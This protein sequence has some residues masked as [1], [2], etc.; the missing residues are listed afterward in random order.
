[1]SSLNKITLFGAGG[2]NIGYHLIRAF[3]A[4]GAYHVTVLARSAS[5]TSYPPAVKL[6]K[7]SDFED[8]EELVQAL[9]GQYVLIS[10]VGP[11]AFAVQN[12]LVD[13]CLRAGVTRF[14][15]TEWGFDNDDTACRELCP[16]VFGAKGRF[17]DDVLRP[18]EGEL[19]WTAVASSIWLDWALDTKFLGIDPEA[20]TVR[21]WRDGSAKWSATTL[22]Y[23]AAA[24]VQILK[25]HRATANRRIFL[26]PFETSQREIVAELERQQGVK[27]DEL[28][29]DADAEV[30]AAEHKWTTE[31][32]MSSVYV[33]IPAVVLLPEY[34]TA[35]QTRAKFPIAEAIE[36]VKLPPMSVAGV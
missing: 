27:Y 25:N 15:P 17:V 23:T 33:T 19:E 18:K 31:N 13:A 10:C 36:G 14:I 30:A 3:L 34:G 11:G 20:H 35:F 29:F 12:D 6:V 8:H 16:P 7:I 24:V 26:S 1:M 22:P 4:D 32:D 2:T 9:K 5:T 28:P 21:Y